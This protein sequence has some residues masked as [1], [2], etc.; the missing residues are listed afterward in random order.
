M[1][2]GEST[3]PVAQGQGLRTEAEATRSIEAY[4]PRKLS[5]AETVFLTI[6]VAVGFGLLGAV[7]RGID[8]WVTSN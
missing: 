2:N 6:K 7:V 4:T 8:L 5:V 1:S 3:K